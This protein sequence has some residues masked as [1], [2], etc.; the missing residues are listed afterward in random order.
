MDR[1]VWKRGNWPGDPHPSGTEIAVLL[2]SHISP[3]LKMFLFLLFSPSL[4]LNKTLWRNT[5]G[6]WGSNLLSELLIMSTFGAVM[7]QTRFSYHSFHKVRKMN[8]HPGDP[9][10]VCVKQFVKGYPRSLHLLIRVS[11]LFNLGMSYQEILTATDQESFPFCKDRAVRRFL[12]LLFYSLRTTNYPYIS[13]QI[14]LDKWQFIFHFLT[15]SC[16]QKS[17][18][19]ELG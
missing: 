19:F 15:F 9:L 11:D 10:Y 17:R 1:K 16:A 5:N 3:H 13:A 12:Y 4:F 18:Y 2:Q 7:N 14:C 6:P 8:F